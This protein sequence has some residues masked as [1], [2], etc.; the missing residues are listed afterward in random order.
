MKD[1]R[2]IEPLITAMSDEYASVRVVASGSLER[3]TGKSY[4]D[5][6]ERWQQWWNQIK[7]N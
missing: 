2:A 4:G 5:D 3:I 1:S 6:K 7:N